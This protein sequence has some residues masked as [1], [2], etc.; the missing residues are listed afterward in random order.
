MQCLVLGQYAT[1]NAHALEAFLLHLQSCHFT[2]GTFSSGDFSVDPW[3][4][5]GTIIRL[6]FRMGYHRDPSKLAG[7]SAFDGEMRRRVWI[8]IFQIDTLMSFEMGFPSMIPTEFC[9][10]EPPRNLEYSDFHVGMATLPPSRPDSEYTP[11]LYTIFKSTIMAVFKRIVAHTQ[12]LSV[13]S[14]ER[15]IELDSEMKQAYIKVPEPLQRRDVNR[16]FIDHS[17]LIWQRCTIEVL[18]L[19]GL[20]VLHRRYISYE[21]QSPTFELS[22]RACVEAALGILDRHEDIHRAC[23]FGGRLYEDR[24]IF[25]SLPVHHF[26]M[27]AMVV[28]LD[29]S[30]SMRSRWGV[31]AVGSDY[32]QLARR[33]YRALQSTQR[34]LASKGAD[35]E[36]ARIAVL[37]LDLMLKKVAENNVAIL[38]PDEGPSGDTH[39]AVESEL[40]Y[41]SA[42]S[43]MID[44]PES[45]DWVSS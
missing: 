19:K 33:E 32:Q 42:M 21:L 12:S 26:L 25:S 14:Y 5:M 9:D 17:S 2:N 44:G 27:A 40:P 23:E 15:T 18:Y 10:T 13:P 16:S 37:S 1:G 29:L 24:W 39:L 22:R 7:I 41:A 45:I 20:V 38:L 30:V 35:S 3:F 8:N 43:Q 6:A 4:Q 31:S 36:D 11:T 28:C 34:I